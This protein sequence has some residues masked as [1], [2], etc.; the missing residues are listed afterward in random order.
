MVLPPLS[1]C[2]LGP[3][4]TEVPHGNVGEKPVEGHSR[5]EPKLAVPPREAFRL[6]P[7]MIFFPYDVPCFREYVT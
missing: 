6:E 5:T 4:R 3:N 7:K 1:R 2:V